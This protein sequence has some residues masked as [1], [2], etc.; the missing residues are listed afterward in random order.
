[1]YN[2]NIKNKYNKEVRNIIIAI[3]LIFTIGIIYLGILFK[4]TKASALDSADIIMFIKIFELILAVLA[5]TSCILCYNSTKKEELFI[6]SLMYIVFFVDILLGNVDNMSLDY[7]KI[8]MENYITIATSILRI[9]IL[10]ISIS[11]NSTIKQIIVKN[12][13]KSIVFV[14]SLSICL[15]VLENRQIIIN[16]ISNDEWFITYNGFLVITY[17]VV[18]IT[19]LIKSIKNQEYIY[20]VISASIFFLI[21]KAIYAITGVKSIFPNIKL[22]SISIT[23]IVFIVTIVG[24]NFELLLTLKKNKKLENELIL[25]KEIVDNSKQSCVV[26]YDEEENVKYANNT[27]RDYFKLGKKCEY[28][29]IK[30]ILNQNKNDVSIEKIKEIEEHFLQ[31][32]YWKGSIEVPSIDTTYSCSVQNIYIEG[33]RNIVLIFNDISEKV[34]VKKYLL[35]YEKMKNQEQIRNEFFANI[36]HELRTP[37]NIFYSTVQLLDKKSENISEDFVKTYSTHKQCLKIN[38]QRMLRLINNIVDVTK[39]DIGFIKPNFENIDIVRVVEDITLSV[40]NYAQPKEINI[41]FDTDIEEHIIK[42]DQDMIERIMLNLLSNAIKFTQRSGN[43]YVD[44]YADEQWVHIIIKDD[45]IGIPIEVQDII[46]DRFVQ[47]DKSLTRLNE[48]SGIGLSLVK[49]AIKANEGEIYLDSDGENG[50]EFE[51]LLP[52][53]IIEG[54]EVKLNYEINPLSVELELSDIYELYT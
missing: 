19:Y 47:S 54:K 11:K 31:L 53:K 50:T 35:E 1:M 40:L 12:K 36:S 9:C 25:F 26:I 15:G 32:G 16:T 24:I 34:R 48:G 5:I 28:N 51:I 39:L 8:N 33:E 27:F 52:N 22:L 46:F 37:L 13:V 30:N 17:L 7:K 43:I 20:S 6:I 29:K 44:M 45:G 41:V 3:S 18:C 23:Y 42:C 4:I 14:S 49:S 2:A 10:L 21:I 38:C